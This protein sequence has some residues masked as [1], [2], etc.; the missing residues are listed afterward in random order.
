[1]SQLHLLLRCGRKTL[2]DESV[3]RLQ[4]RRF[5]RLYLTLNI[6]YNMFMAPNKELF[7][8]SSDLCICY[9][10]C[11]QI[12]NSFFYSDIIH[13]KKI[14]LGKMFNQQKHTKKAGKRPVSTAIIMKATIMIDIKHVVI[15]FHTQGNL[16][17]INPVCMVK[18]VNPNTAHGK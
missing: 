4:P 7:F 17:I 5:S 18:Y 3:F 11:Y 14:V 12:R 16:P 2:T 1:M 8:Y 9:I 13:G 10:I 15:V 6:L